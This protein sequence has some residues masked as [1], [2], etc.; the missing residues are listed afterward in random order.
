L[1]RSALFSLVANTVQNVVR[2]DC[3]AEGDKADIPTFDMRALMSIKAYLV[4]DTRCLEPQGC[5]RQ[6]TRDK[7]PAWSSW[8]VMLPDWPK[9]VVLNDLLPPARVILRSL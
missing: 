6:K 1:K 9:V 8:Q 7:I 2:F 3:Y 5:C 4:I